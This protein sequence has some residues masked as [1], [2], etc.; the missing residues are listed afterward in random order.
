M[1]NYVSKNKL[2]QNEIMRIKRTHDYGKLAVKELLER[3]K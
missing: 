1:K 2:K 3:K